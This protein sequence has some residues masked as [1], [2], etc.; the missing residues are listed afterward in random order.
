VAPLVTI[1]KVEEDSRVLASHPLTDL[2]DGD[3]ME[4]VPGHG[5]LL[6]VLGVE[7]LQSSLKTLVRGAA[8]G[9][10]SPLSKSGFLHVDASDL[11]DGLH[12]GV[13][14]AVVIIDLSKIARALVGVDTA[15]NP[16]IVSRV[17]VLS[18]NCCSNKSKNENSSHFIKK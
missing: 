6:A 3:I 16:G 15:L 8:G 5:E 4:V 10:A 17:G 11:V 14:T 18:K 7:C 12:E 9:G 13:R 1:E 2:L